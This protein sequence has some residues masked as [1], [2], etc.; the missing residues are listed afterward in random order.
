MITT[1]I[2]RIFLY[3]YYWEEMGFFN[4]LS[5]FFLRTF[6]IAQY[7]SPEGYSTAVAGKKK[8]FRRLK[9]LGFRIARSHKMPK[10]TSNKQFFGHIFYSAHR[11][12]LD[13]SL[14]IAILFWWKIMLLKIMYGGNIV[15]MRSQSART[16]YTVYICDSDIWHIR[17]SRGV[18]R[19]DENLIQYDGY[20]NTE[21]MK[22]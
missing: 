7:S 11:K 2:F 16:L 19:W 13:A 10:L 5:M 6:Y 8:N 3:T 4:I 17:Y 21:S 12:L 14:G 20:V 9:L 1:Q 22:S 15:P 18:K